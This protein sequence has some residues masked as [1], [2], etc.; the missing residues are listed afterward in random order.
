MGNGARRSAA[1]LGDEL[2]APTILPGSPFAT[3][4]GRA[5]VHISTGLVD[6]QNGRQKRQQQRFEF[7][8]QAQ[9]FLTPHAAIN[10]TFAIRG[11]L[12]SKPILRRFR[13]WAGAA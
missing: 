10:H 9:R 3:M 5:P 13:A 7:Q 1:S 6:L 2:V 8:T 12:I 4:P 11:R